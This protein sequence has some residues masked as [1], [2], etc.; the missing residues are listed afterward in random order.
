MS[1]A[2]CMSVSSSIRAT[3]SGS[4]ARSTSRPMTA[5][6]S[7]GYFQGRLPLLSRR[8]R[9]SAVPRAA[10][11]P[12]NASIL[13]AG[14]SDVA[15]EVTRLLRDQGA[16]VWHLQQAEDNR[17]HIEGMGAIVVK[18]DAARADQIDAAMAGIDGLQAVVSTL[19]SIAEPGTSSGG[20]L[21]T[22]NLVRA[23][24]GLSVEKFVL[25]GAGEAV[26]HFKIYD[27]LNYVIIEPRREGPA[28][29]QEVAQTL[30]Q[31]LVTDAEDGK[32]VPS[33]GAASSA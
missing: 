5:A 24:A 8:G 21:G 11:C 4:P 18:A 22:V 16:W 33:S 32:V 29:A 25:L 3:Q 13:V 26:D 10:I 20:T 28:S 23:A 27:G 9:R 12:D 17:E 14:E 2:M 1:L 15:L 7:G 31:A 6:T 30:V 19:G